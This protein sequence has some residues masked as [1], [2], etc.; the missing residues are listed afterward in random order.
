MVR[1]KELLQEML[2]AARRHNLA[3]RQNDLALLKD[4]ISLEEDL[5]NKLKAEKGQEEKIQTALREKL[6]LPAD[7]PWSAMVAALP[8]DLSARLS[9]L[10]GEMRG[11]AGEIAG[12]VELNRILTHQAMHF[13]TQLLNLLR[14]APNSM[15]KSD[16]KSFGAASLSSALIN[17]TV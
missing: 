13:N 8:G 16:G 11:I 7:A 4:A 17:K 10:A 9:G 3:L 2:E 5:S 12:V 15:Y 1:Q 6:S 14:A